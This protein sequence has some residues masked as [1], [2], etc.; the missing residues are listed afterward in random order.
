[1][2]VGA[3]ISLTS[4]PVRRSRPALGFVFN[5]GA[6]PAGAAFARAGTALATN[7]SGVL[8]GHSANVPRFDHDPAT[9]AYRGL[10]IEPTRT[11]ASLSSQAFGG[12]AWTRRGTFSATDNAIAAPDGTI[13]GSLWS[14]VQFAG[15]GDVFDTSYAAPGRFASATVCSAS[16]WIRPVSSVGRLAA[17]DPNSNL[18]GFSVNLALLPP[19]VWTWIS[20]AHPAVTQASGFT[21]NAAGMLALQFFCTQGAPISAHLWGVQLE[22]GARSSSYIPTTS[23][24]VTRAADMLT[25]NWASKG[26]ADGSHVMRYAFDDGSTQDVATTVIGGAATVPTSLNRPWIRAVERL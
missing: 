21:S 13:T 10:L 16:F 1:M 15:T 17:V 11:N 7:P 18:V 14:G 9:R 23:T 20:A 25:L 22:A 19:G 8:V 26:V 4:V 24:A 6:L 2:S 3:D 12:S 5:A